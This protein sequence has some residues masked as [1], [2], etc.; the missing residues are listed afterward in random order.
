MAS[1]F[2]PKQHVASSSPGINLSKIM[3][4]GGDKVAYQSFLIEP[5][6]VGILCIGYYLFFLQNDKEEFVKC[7]GY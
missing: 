2:H 7:N 6:K 1:I 3:E 5:T 4:S